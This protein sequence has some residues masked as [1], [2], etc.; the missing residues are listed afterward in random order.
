MEKKDWKKILRGVALVFALAGSLVLLIFTFMINDALD[1][2]EKSVVSNI[3]G[4]QGTLMDVE[5]AV[6]EAD[7]QLNATA[8]TIDDLSQSFE[9]I[10]TGLDS[11]GNAL[12]GVSQTLAGI[13]LLGVNLGS[14][15]AELEDA[16][17]SMFT[18]SD[19]LGDTNF[20]E[21]AENI[22]EFQL[23]LQGIKDDIRMQRQTLDD[24][25]KSVQEVIGLVKIAN[26]LLF[27][28]II[29]MFIILILDSAAGLI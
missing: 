9:P 8:Q 17:N 28:V 6:E 19:S 29:S 16:A 3:E 7:Q 13:N 1:K 21:Q 5:N 10:A 14:Q 23:S 2:T 12:V 24:T 20:D 4:I 15:A 26:V 11:T 27:F 22:G 25:K 18:A